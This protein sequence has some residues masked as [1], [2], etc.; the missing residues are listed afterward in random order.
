MK[1]HFVLAAT[2]SV[3][4]ANQAK[5][6]H[7]H[8]RGHADYSSW[9]SKKTGNCCNNDDCGNLE[10]NEWRET[11][12]GDEIRISG[13][14]CPVKQEHYLVKGKSPD[15]TKAHACVAKGADHMYSNPCNRL[16][17]FTGVPKF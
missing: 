9:S 8:E 17:C 10:D 1:W 15:W 7:N 14:W 6:Q 3:L 13:Q 12:H 4:F 5:A 11:D 16:L 2:V